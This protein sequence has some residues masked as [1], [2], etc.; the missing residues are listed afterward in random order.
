MLDWQRIRRTFLFG[1]VVGV[2]F[3][4]VN[5]LIAW[6]YPLADDTPAAVFRFYGPMF[7]LWALVAFRAA[8]RNGRLLSGLA[9]GAIVAFGTF[10]AY[11]LLIL[12][13]VNLFLAELTGRADWQS[14]M[15]RFRASDYESL[16]LFVNLDYLK[17]TPLKLGAALA[18]GAIM[19]GTGGFLGH[20]T[21]RRLLASA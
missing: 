18:I 1:L 10:A 5:L 20:M 9:A 16:R 11:D 6:Q 19:G 21:H 12:L 15:A 2:V 8:R 3:G 14:M 4:S 7:F 13:R 17:G